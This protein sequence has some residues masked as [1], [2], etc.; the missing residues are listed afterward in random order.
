MGLAAQDK[1]LT[2]L[3]LEDFLKVE[4][5]SVRKSQQRLSRTPAAVYVI[6][7]DDIRRSAAT[8]LPEALR[9][10]PGVHVARQCRQWCDQCHHQEGFGHAGDNDGGLRRIDGP[11][12]L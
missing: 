9:M 12:P 5:V 2:S 11:G 8:S 6:T 1:D 7:Q 4:V 3:S 10:V